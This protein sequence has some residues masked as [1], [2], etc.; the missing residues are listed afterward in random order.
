MFFRELYVFLASSH[1]EGHDVI[2][3]TARFATH[4]MNIIIVFNEENRISSL[5]LNPERRRS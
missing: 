5:W 4:V 2:T 1:S 3:V